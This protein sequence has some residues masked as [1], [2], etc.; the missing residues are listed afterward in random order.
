MKLP[1]WRGLALDEGILPE[2][3][4]DG[5][6]IVLWRPAGRDG[7]FQ[8]W[9]R[10]ANVASADVT[11]QQ[12]ICATAATSVRARQRLQG[13][14]GKLVQ[15]FRGATGGPVWML[16]NGESAEQ[17]GERQTDLLLVWTLEEHPPLDEARIRARWPETIRLEKIANNLF[18]VSGVAPPGAGGEAEP[19]QG[20]PRELA[21]QLLAAARATGDRRKEASA[22]TDLGIVALRAGDARGAAA[23]L[24]EALAIARQ[25][26][27]RPAEL[28]GLGYLGLAAV[29]AG[30]PRRALELFEQH[31]AQARAAGDRFGEKVALEHLGH[32]WSAMRDPARAIAFFEEALAL[33]RAV[34][35]RL[36]QA[37]LLWDLGIQYAERGQGDQAITTAQAAV[38]LYG[39]MG[40]PQAASF[41]DHLQRYRLGQTAA[42]LGPGSGAGRLAPPGAAFG[43]SIL[44]GAGAGQPGPSPVPGQPAS[45][46]GLLRMAASA[47]KS[48]ARF[49]GSGLRTATPQT[50]RI[51]LRTCAACEHHT[52]VRCRLCGCFTNAKAWMRHEECPAGKWPA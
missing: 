42:A 33:A 20:Q 22:L 35:D 3:M 2:P 4:A 21:E 1:D 27:D 43:G 17:W 31:L 39:K 25:L 12:G 32:A 29:N 46:P 14:L 37:D 52:G 6:R 7:G 11:A 30:Q 18:L 45:G 28:D 41:A 36:H 15:R 13:F 26:G 44:A 47:A 51:R 34:G 10:I 50:H 5:N 9:E 23:L 8:H 48:M 49:F 19:P 16:P 38:D 24:E 40:H